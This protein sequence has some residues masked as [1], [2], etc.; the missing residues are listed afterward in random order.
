MQMRIIRIWLRQNYT[1]QRLA[2]VKQLYKSLH[3]VAKKQH[4]IYKRALI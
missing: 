3:Y 4:P 1:T 2:R